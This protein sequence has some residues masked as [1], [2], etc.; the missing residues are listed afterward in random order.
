MTTLTVPGRRAARPERRRQSRTA[1]IAADRGAGRV[2]EARVAAKAA[3]SFAARAVRS[4][5]AA[6]WPDAGGEADGN[7]APSEG[8]AQPAPRE[9]DGNV[10]PPKPAMPRDDDD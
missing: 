1:E 6:A 9:V 2:A 8:S 7:V 4:E 10:A 3:A 5:P